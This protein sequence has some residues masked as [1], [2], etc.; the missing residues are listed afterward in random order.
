VLQFARVAHATD[1]IY[2]YSIMESNRRTEYAN[3]RSSSNTLL[4]H[5]SPSASIHPAVLGELAIAELNTF[6]P[7]DPYKLPQSS[8]YIQKVY[9]EWSAVSIDEEDE[10]EDNGE[11]GELSLAGD[12]YGPLDIPSSSTA[13]A[14]D[15]DVLGTSFE[16]MSI[17]PA[18][19]QL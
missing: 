9:R 18:R 6:F 2:C 1:F 7:F 11:E 5:R 15:S 4:V 10:D 12:P 17:S 13:Q 19:Q 14:N 3:A 8:S 16:G